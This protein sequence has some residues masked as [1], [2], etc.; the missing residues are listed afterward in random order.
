ME[1]TVEDDSGKSTWLMKDLVEL[2][3]MML[4][5]SPIRFVVVLMTGTLSVPETRISISRTCV[6]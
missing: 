6:S 4:P 2:R 1:M 3:V 5:S